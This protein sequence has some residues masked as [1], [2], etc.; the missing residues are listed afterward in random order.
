MTPHCKGWG[1]P[2]I[3]LCQDSSVLRHKL[4]S[5]KPDKEG[6]FDLEPIDGDLR[7]N[8][9]K[10]ERTVDS[11]HLITY[12][13]C[14]WSI[15]GQHVAAI[16]GCPARQRLRLEAATTDRSDAPAEL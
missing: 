6:R 5:H 16:Q 7:L 2:A 9:H 11:F 14:L 3:R 15:Y 8:Q 4:S 12:K 10:F 13:S 1:N